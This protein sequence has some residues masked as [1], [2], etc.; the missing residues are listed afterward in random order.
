[1][2]VGMY[3][4]FFTRHWF[5]AEA[6][7]IWADTATLQ[8]WLDVE[9]ALARAQADIGMIPPAA[10]DVIAANADARAFDLDKLTAATIKTLHPFVP[11]L[12][13]FE[14][15]CGP[16]AAGYIHWGA[17]TQNIFD[18]AVA[19]QL[20]AAHALIIRDLDRARAT[21]ARLARET[22]DVPQAGRTH[23]QH[24]LPI[25][26]GFK[27]AGWHAELTRE[28][29]HIESRTADAF[30]ASMG[31]AVGTFAA[32]NGRGRAVQDA[33]ATLLGLGSNPVPNRSTSDGFAAYASALAPFAATVEKIANE[34]VFLQR[35]EIAEVEERFDFGKVGSSTMAHKRNPSHALNLIGLAKMLRSR[36]PLI[37]EAM[38]RTNEGD[39][40][41][42]NAGDS[43]LP[44]VS[45][46]AASLA[47]GLVRLVDG[48]T[49]DAS[50]MAR[51]LEASGGMILTE[52]IMM[53]IAPLIGRHR[54]HD[55]LYEIAM[56]RAR[57]GEAFETLLER[58]SVLAPHLARIDL[59]RLLDPSHYLGE[60]A[61]MADAAASSP[62]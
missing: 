15:L 31:G 13:Q 7:A 50:A 34:V 12:H 60:A 26:F 32:M 49:V 21:I 39:A 10:A 30:V 62:H 51:N 46:I 23:G 24:A 41:A 11:V 36:A 28:R 22:R 1:M 16:E 53:E 45:I 55:L 18:T 35:T 37:V 42:S 8:A 40:A 57:T 59:K 56:E 20:R 27:L 47:E 19:L 2:A 48:M 52:A 17:T 44:E 9:V 43:A 33:V 14:A 54:A 5:S 25:T 6:K 29:A 58:H 61:A 3:D 4:S 38:V